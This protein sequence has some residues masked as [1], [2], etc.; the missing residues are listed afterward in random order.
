MFFY[1]YHFANHIAGHLYNISQFLIKLG[2]HF[3][4]IFKMYC[5]YLL[6]TNIILSCTVKLIYNIFIHQIML[7]SYVSISIELICVF[8]V[9]SKF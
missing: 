4:S 3:N 6:A 2:Q 9:Q 1:S 8:Y 7:V 5:I